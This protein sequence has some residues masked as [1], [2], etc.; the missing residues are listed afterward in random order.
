M[1]IDFEFLSQV[2]I[3]FSVVC[4]ILAAVGAGGLDLYL[5]STQWVMMGVILGVWAVYVKLWKKK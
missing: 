1:E 5:A 4:L 3:L 2:L